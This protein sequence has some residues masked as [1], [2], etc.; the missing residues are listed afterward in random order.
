VGLRFH[1]ELSQKYLLSNEI[2]INLKMATLFNKITIK[3]P[4]ENIF[5]A[6]SQMEGFE[7]LD[8]NV[9]KSISLSTI[10]SGLNASR[11]V[12]M[13]DGKNWFK[14]KVTNLIPNESITYELTDCSFPVKSLRYTYTLTKSGSETLVDQNMSYDMKYGILGKMMDSLMIKKQYNK[15]IRQFFTGL[16]TFAEN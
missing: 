3:A 11:K 2:K 13:M 15:G 10:A 8:P 9:K 4:V 1:N 6:L 14:E 16:K 5:Q 12:E 7:N